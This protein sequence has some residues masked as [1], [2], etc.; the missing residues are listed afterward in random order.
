MLSLK[1]QWRKKKKDTSPLF[2]GIN[3]FKVYL[4]EIG[5]KQI[6]ENLL[7]STSLV[8][9]WLRFHVP[10]AGD[11]GWITGRGTRPHIPQL[12]VHRL[13]LRLSVAKEIKINIKKENNPRTSLVVQGLRICLP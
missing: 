2:P 6:L 10:N 12:R 1:I 4:G 9:H 13:Q 5:V 11:I 7:Y 3:E 8:V